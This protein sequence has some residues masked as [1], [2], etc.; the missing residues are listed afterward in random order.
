MDDLR[1]TANG[2]HDRNTGNLGWGK[3]PLSR[4]QLIHGAGALA[5]LGLAGLTGLDRGARRASAAGP[6][7]RAIQAAALQLADT[8]SVDDVHSFVSRPDLQP[9]VVTINT[10]SQGWQDASPN[11]IFLATKGYLGAAPGQPGLMIVDRYGRLIWFKP[12]S[13]ASPFDFNMQSYKGQ[14]ALTWW[15]GKV[16]PG[17]GYGEGQIANSQYVATNTVHAGDGLQADLH[18]LL[19]TSAGTALITAYQT[20]TTNMSSL[21]GPDKGPVYACHAQEIDLATG[22]VLLDWNSLSHIALDESYLGLPSG[23]AKGTPMDYFHINSVQEMQNGNLLISGRNTWAI[24]E[25]DR[26]T[27][28]V[29]WR[30]NG[31]RS[32]FKMGA[33]SNFYWQ[34]HAVPHA[35][36][37]FTVFDDGSSPPEEKQSRGLLLFVDTTTMHV[38]LKQAYINPAGFIAANQGSVQLL[39]DGRVFVGWGNQPYFSEFAPDGTLLMDGQL[40]LNVQSYRAFTYDWTG[41]PPG[42]PDVA[43]R[44]NPAGGFIVY[45]SWNGATE[46][47]KWTVL[48]GSVASRMEPVGSQYWA[49]FETAIAVNSGGPKFCAVALDGSGKELGRSAVVN[50]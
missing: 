48:A 5:T 44:P 32:D 10:Y 36:G 33:G 41:K 14:P 45:M 35:N 11:Y 37:L 22:K 46:V 20:T 13:P 23:K 17:I 8:V 21:N 34:H 1:R 31:K 6:G 24:Y 16:G 39:A 15:Q 12:I 18:E 3:R 7:T 4:R 30:M 28:K 27:G 29:L 9:P 42:S 40:P 26:S 2:G 38:S 47:H 50:A 25:V 49:D 43:V 19:I